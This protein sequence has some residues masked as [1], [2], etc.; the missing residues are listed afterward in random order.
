M[1]GQADVCSWPSAQRNTQTGNRPQHTHTLLHAASW[2]ACNNNLLVRV[3]RWQ[4]SPGPRHILLPCRMRTAPE[5]GCMVPPRP[6]PAR[7]Q[8]CQRLT[9]L[10]TAQGWFSGSSTSSRSSLRNAL[11]SN[12]DATARGRHLS[13]RT[14]AE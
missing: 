5:P 9:G 2:L 6:G 4:T 3:P 13:S 14:R 1:A 7:M 10:L 8:P 12:G 11:R